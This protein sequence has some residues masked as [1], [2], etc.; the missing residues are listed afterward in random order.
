MIMPRKRIRTKENGENFSAKKVKTDGSD[1]EISDEDCFKPIEKDGESVLAI[2][3]GPNKAYMYLSKLYQGSKGSCV[4]FQGSWLTPNEFQFVS[5]RESAKDWK[6]SIRHQGLSLKSLFTRG[7]LSVRKLRQN[8]ENTSTKPSGIKDTTNHASGLRGRKVNQKRGKRRRI[9]KKL[10]IKATELEALDI[11]VSTAEKSD[12]RREGNIQQ[13]ENEQDSTSDPETEIDESN[14]VNT[15]FDERGS[16]AETT[17]DDSNNQL[18]T[19]NKENDADMTMEQTSEAKCEEIKD[20]VETIEENMAG[21]GASYSGSDDANNSPMPVLSKEEIT[22][23]FKPVSHISVEMKTPV[24]DTPAP[25][26]DERASPPRLDYC[27]SVMVADEAD[28][29]QGSVNRSKTPS[30]CSY[31]ADDEFHVKVMSPKSPQSS[32][33]LTIK[34][35]HYPCSSLPANVLRTSTPSKVQSPSVSPPILSQSSKSSVISKDLN[36]SLVPNK[37]TQT[38][39]KGTDHS[40]NDKTEASVKAAALNSLISTLHMSVAKQQNNSKMVIQTQQYSERSVK[41]SIDSRRSTPTHHMQGLSDNRSQIHAGSLR[42]NK[43]KRH[44]LSAEKSVPNATYKDHAQSKPPVLANQGCIR[45]VPP[46]RSKGKID[47]KR[48]RINLEEPHKSKSVSSPKVNIDQDLRGFA[49]G[50]YLPDCH[51]LHNKMQKDYNEYMALLASAYRQPFPFFP[52]PVTGPSLPEMYS[53]SKLQEN[54]AQTS[55]P[56]S[57]DMIPVHPIPP[58]P[59]D[60]SHLFNPFPAFTP[61][62]PLGVPPYSAIYPVPSTSQPEKQVKE[63]KLVQKATKMEQ[64]E[65]NTVLD[66]SKKNLPRID[67]VERVFDYSKPLDFS[68]KGDKTKDNGRMDLKWNSEETYVHKRHRSPNV[69]NSWI[70]KSDSIPKANAEVSCK[71]GSDCSDDIRK[72]TVDQVCNFLT[73]LDGCAMYEKVR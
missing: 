45:P 21:N 63:I 31:E 40:T 47:T 6:R 72:W 58:Y 59:L 60:Y 39:L 5:G 27:S 12:K 62:F 61:R 64:K 55:S 66:L 51:A 54:R 28:T 56:L 57:K 70:E 50:I 16:I 33:S 4:S 46:D 22:K 23:D 48:L 30:K 18:E 1:E 71:C 29:S 26:S 9:I 10:T 14:T 38:F 25:T 52:V 67:R 13:Q 24:L 17:C 32:A 37:E 53:Y 65:Q 2:E 73:R 49:N 8:E 41:Q 42:F 43:P 44:S 68:K 36:A 35:Q 69:S 15:D 19:I 11:V 34:Q 7:I 3:C 20:E